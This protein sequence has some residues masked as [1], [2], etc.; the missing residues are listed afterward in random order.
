MITPNEAKPIKSYIGEL[1]AKIAALQAENDQLRKA[2][3][4]Y[5]KCAMDCIT[6]K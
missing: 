2:V 5:R 6:D 4:C 3:E 1:T